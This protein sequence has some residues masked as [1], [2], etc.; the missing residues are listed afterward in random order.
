MQ[1]LLGR[2]GKFVQGPS[3]LCQ[4]RERHL[5]SSS[6]PMLRRC[7]DD[8]FGIVQMLTDNSFRRRNGQI[9]N[10]QIQFAI[11]DRLNY[12]FLRDIAP[13]AVRPWL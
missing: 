9:V 6:Q 1:P 11:Y 13:V 4:F 5:F 8:I 10:D 3:L 2:Q 7:A 12:N